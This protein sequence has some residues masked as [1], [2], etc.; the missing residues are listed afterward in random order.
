MK[1]P[2]KNLHTFHCD[3]FANELITLKS[4]S[5]ISQ[6]YDDGFYA[7]SRWMLLGGGSNVLFIRDFGGVILLNRLKGR[8][9][10]VKNASTALV[11]LASGEVWHEVVLWSLENGFNGIENL[12]L[13]PGTVGAA[14]MQ[15]IG[16]YGVELKDVFHSLRAFDTI[17]GEIVTLSKEDCNFGYR[18]SVFK[19]ELKG[20]MIILTVDLLLRRDGISDVSYGDILKTLELEG[21]PKP[22]KPK[23]VSDAIIQIR[24]SKLPDPVVLGNAGSFFKNPVIGASYFNEL[25]TEHPDMPGY[26]LN[27]DEVKVPAGWLI[28]HCGYKGR[29]VGNTGSHEKQALV[30]VN[31]GNATGSEIR[32]LA[33]EIQQAVAGK[34][35]IEILPEVNFVE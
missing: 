12:S 33:M 13:I 2:L 7:S 4:P 9:I 27:D 18:D 23:D 35:G 25:K 3:V 28:E 31:Y 5:H 8:E 34:Y 15:N 29:R 32:A 14:P 21:A 20:R 22:Y 16:A 26:K 17:T 30:L 6:L 10:L 19:H 24:Q 11:R 1:I